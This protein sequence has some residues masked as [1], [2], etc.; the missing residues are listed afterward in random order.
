M[1]KKYAS[2]LLTLIAVLGMGTAAKA[3]TRGGLKVT[4]PFEFVVDGKTLP[5]GTYTVSH[6]AHDKNEVLILN[7]YE[8]RTSVFLLPIGVDSASAD[9]DEVSFQRLGEQLFLSS[10]RIGHDV[11]SIPVPRSA[12]LEAAGRPHENTGSSDSS[13]NN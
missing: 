7:N 8:V 10:I 12:V 2:I 5:A 1:K 6:L 4:L 11:Y 9:K 3:E 13:G